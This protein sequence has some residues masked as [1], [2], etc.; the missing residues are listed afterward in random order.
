MRTLIA[1]VG[2]IFF[3]DDGFGVE[4]ARRLAL[5]RLPHHVKVADYG[6]RG[7]HL[8]FELV[9]GYDRAIVIDAVPRGGQ[10]GTLYVI[11]PDLNALA[12]APDSHSMELAN[13]FA[14]MKRLE[15]PRPEITIVGCEPA[16]AI[17][18]MELS[19][20][21]RR[22]IEPAVALVRSLLAR[23]TTLP[24]TQETTT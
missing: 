6:I 24:L 14:F 2:N 3:G 22:A 13:V 18:R 4:V 23:E 10:A 9:S 20:P 16:S 21:V 1:G 7:V 8:A 19:E 15:G 5:E 11:E 17:E 12:P